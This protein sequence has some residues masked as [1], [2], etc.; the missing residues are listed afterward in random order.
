M[1]A[2][3]GMIRLE[4]QE[5][6]RKRFNTRYPLVRQMDKARQELIT[7]ASRLLERR[8]PLNLASLAEKNGIIHKLTTA[9]EL[10][11][12]L[13][14]PE[15]MKGSVSDAPDHGSKVLKLSVKRLG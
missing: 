11:I 15:Q 7:V 10:S 13:R 2:A 5:E 4:L 6:R 8:R 14:H 3:L 12:K 1:G 9:V